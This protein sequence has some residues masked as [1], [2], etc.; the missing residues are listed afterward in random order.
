M[1]AAAQ[2]PTGCPMSGEGRPLW[3][4]SCCINPRPNLSTKFEDCLVDHIGVGCDR[5]GNDRINTGFAS[6]MACSATSSTVPANVRASTCQSV[7]NGNKGRYGAIP[8]L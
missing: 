4:P 6:A 1:V 2:R 3:V 5:P 8:A 7:I